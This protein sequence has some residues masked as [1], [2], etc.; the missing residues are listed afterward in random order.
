MHQNKKGG[1]VGNPA[2]V[3]PDCVMA[4]MLTDY[5]SSRGKRETPSREDETEDKRSWGGGHGKRRERK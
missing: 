3:T 5:Q 1:G 2:D 4:L